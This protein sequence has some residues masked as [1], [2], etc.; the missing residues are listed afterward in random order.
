MQDLMNP[1]GISPGQQQ[2]VAL[3]DGQA[4]KQDSQVSCR[5]PV[6][7]HRQAV[8]ISFRSHSRR[9]CGPRSRRNRGHMPT[10]DSRCTNR[11]RCRR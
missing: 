9:A 8:V 1:E 3:E 2:A 10:S 4:I 11:S 7:A 5:Q 6:Q